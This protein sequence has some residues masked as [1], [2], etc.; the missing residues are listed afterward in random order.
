MILDSSEVDYLE[1]SESEPEELGEDK[2]DDEE[3]VDS[4]TNRGIHIK[5]DSRLPNRG[6]PKTGTSLYPLARRVYANGAM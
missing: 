4:D 2:D 3:D 5:A 6:L 1:G